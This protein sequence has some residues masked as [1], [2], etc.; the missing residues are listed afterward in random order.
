MKK[1]YAI[2]D[3]DADEPNGEIIFSDTY[4]G[5]IK[6]YCVRWHGGIYD[7]IEE[8]LS[9]RRAANMDQHRESPNS[10]PDA[11]FLK[12]GWAVECDGCGFYDHDHQVLGDRA[13][14]QDCYDY[15]TLPQQKEES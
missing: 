6:D 1:A 9:V 7:D 2:Y 14:C 3:I 13:L 10:I 8:S 4:T 15:K 5:A 12:I 11:E